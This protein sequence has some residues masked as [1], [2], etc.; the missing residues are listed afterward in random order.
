MF[1]GGQIRYH[2]NI[3]E[4]VNNNHLMGKRPDVIRAYV[5]TD[6]RTDIRTYAARGPHACAR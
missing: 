1:T 5:R 6:I 3:T 2:V 4:S